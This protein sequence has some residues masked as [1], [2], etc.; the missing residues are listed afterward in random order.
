MELYELV[1]KELRP[2]NTWN[3]VDAKVKELALQKRDFSRAW[4]LQTLNWLG[5]DLG[6]TLS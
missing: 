3:Q 1:R 5:L 2:G 4:A 6:S